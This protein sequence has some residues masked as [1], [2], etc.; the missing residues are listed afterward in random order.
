MGYNNSRWLR[1]LLFGFVAAAFVFTASPPSHAINLNGYKLITSLTTKATYDDNYF[2]EATNEKEAWVFTSTP[3][4]RLEIGETSK[5]SLGVKSDLIVVEG[6]SKE[7][8]QNQT[9]SASF[10]YNPGE[11]LSFLIEDNLMDVEDQAAREGEDRTQRLQNDLSATLTYKLTEKLGA[12][13]KMLWRSYDFDVFNKQ[14][15][16]DEYHVTVRGT[17]LIF[18]RTEAFVGYRYSD[19][20]FTALRFIL[21]DPGGRTA[22]QLDMDNQGHTV[23]VGLK[24]HQLPVGAGRLQGEIW[25]GYERIDFQNQKDQDEIVLEGRLI[26]LPTPRSNVV[27]LAR[28][29]HNAS[30]LVSGVNVINSSIRLDVI[31]RFYERFQIS[32]GGGYR[33]S[34]YEEPVAIRVSKGAPTRPERDDDTVSLR[35]GLR[36]NFYKYFSAGVNYEFI[37]KNVDPVQLRDREYQ[38]N[39]ISVLLNGTF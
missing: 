28:R 19:F 18:P 11:R 32:A 29:E 25:G 4:V 26:Y 27:L 6:F 37:D 1:T 3:D 16:R 13:T 34:N 2:L 38:Q 14:L 30:P 17:Y 21:P 7:N 15:T 24:F 35:A 12:E 22:A 31:Y 10:E 5:L 39:R 8:R 36:Y 23:Q 9:Y 20:V 33:N